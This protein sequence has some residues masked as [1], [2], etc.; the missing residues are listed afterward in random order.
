MRHLCTSTV[1]SAAPGVVPRF[2]AVLLLPLA[3]GGACSH[4]GGG[5]AGDG[6]SGSGGGVGGTGGKGGT[7]GSGGTTG[8]SGGMS[9]SG[10]AGGTGN[11][12]GSGGMGASGGVGGTGNTGGSGGTSARDGGSANDASSDGPASKDAPKATYSFPPVNSLPD[13][14]GMPDPFRKPDGTR[15]ATAAEWPEQRAYLKAL[16]EHYLYGT[17]PPKPMGNELTFERTSDAAYSPPGSTIAGRRQGYRITI[18]RGGKQHSFTFNLWRPAA[19]QRYPMLINN[20]RE[21]S[22]A[23]QGPSSMDE[24]VR[25]GYAVVEFSH[26]EVAP[27]DPSNA[28]RARGIFPLYPEY[29]FATIA[30]W[31][32]AYQPVIDT[33]DQLGVIDMDKIITTGHSRGG[34]TAMAGAILDERVAI[35][36]PSTGGPYS[37]GSTRQR[38]P[39]GARGTMDYAANNRA[40][41]PHWFHPRYH[42][43]AGKQ[44]LQPWDAST[45][46]ALVAPRPLL[47]LNAVA[48]P[49]NN[50]LAHEVGIRV[51]QVIYGF[52]GAEQ[53]PRLHW[54]DVTNMFGQTGHDE[55]PEEWLAIFDFA[56]EV[57][58]GKPRGPSTYNVAPKSNTWRYNPAQF[59]LLID[60]SVPA[61]R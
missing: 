1:V 7:S 55:G 41:Q 25:R 4:T 49:F 17:I 35:A 53:L 30:A 36:A 48:D 33:L 52:W 32:W 8:G 61:G 26:S 50:S 60:W 11:T 29:S 37:V 58:F 39:S 51:A 43:F 12:S 45:L 34:Q 5:S 20:H 27:D 21:H 9:A 38:D 3:L 14:K 19:E 59:P 22:N 28:N 47:N 54:R 44:N 31:G 18:T 24:G 6:G 15:V 16:L 13:L 57:F 46:V 10:G 23:N 40:A 42:E 56:D 2:A